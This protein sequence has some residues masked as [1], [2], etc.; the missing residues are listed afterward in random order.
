MIIKGKKT[1]LRAIEQ[2][3]FQLLLD[4]IN[5][6]ETEYMLGGWSFPV[7]QQMQMDWVV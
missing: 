7:S 1:I 5:D 2:K 6:P 4:L 3:D